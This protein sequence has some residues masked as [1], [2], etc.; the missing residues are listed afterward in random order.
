MS[1]KT[2]KIFVISL[3]TALLCIAA[4]VFFALKIQA[5][6]VRLEE[7]VAILTESN[8]KESAYVRLKRLVQDT[9]SKRTLLASSFFKDEGDSIIFLGEIETLASALGLSLETES[10]DKIVDETT[11][12]EAIRITF[13]FEGAKDTVFTFSKLMEVAP[14]HSQVESLALRKLSNENWQGTLTIV[15]SINAL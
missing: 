8:T 15:I 10:L 7:Q 4:L 12:K 5:E 11:K 13:E 3:V 6:G 2:K 14:Y 1:S 9:E